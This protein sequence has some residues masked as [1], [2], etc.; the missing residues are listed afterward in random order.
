MFEFGRW[1]DLVRELAGWNVSRYDEILRWPLR[2]ALA[3][4]EAKLREQAAEDYRTELL[5]F[6]V[7]APYLKKDARPPELPEILR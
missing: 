4:Y 2:E 3:S 1:S 7:Q 6:A 5:C